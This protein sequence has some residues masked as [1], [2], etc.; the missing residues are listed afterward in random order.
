M[1]TVEPAVNEL[2]QATTG[3]Q[4]L[5][6]CGLCIKSISSKSAVKCA[7]CQV[8]CHVS[9]IVTKFVASG[10][11]ECKHSKEW[12]G[13]FLNAGPFHYSCSTCLVKNPNKSPGDISALTTVPSA[14]PQ[15]C[16]DV[17]LLHQEVAGMKASFT[18]MSG[19]MNQM[20]KRMSELQ[21]SLSLC[22][23]P[24][25]S[26]QTKQDEDKP[27]SAPVS[28]REQ[29]PSHVSL[30]SDTKSFKEAVQQAVA[31]SIKQQSNKTR[32]KASVVVHGL[33]ENKQDSRDVA[34][35][36]R[37][38]SINCVPVTGF[39]M[40]QPPKAVSTGRPRPLKVIFGSQDDKFA[41]LRA[42]RHLRD[43]REFCAVHISTYLSADEMNKVKAKRAECER[44]NRE[45]GCHS[46]PRKYVV[47]DGDIKERG[48]DGKLK[49]YRPS[50]ESTSVVH[51][52][53]PRSSASTVT[54][55]TASLPTESARPKPTSSQSK[56]GSVGSQAAPLI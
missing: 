26:G 17:A 24:V 52:T 33:P 36:L 45:C 28:V 39:R 5:S 7:T 46:S 11:K 35:M 44:L 56:N 14:E 22:A 21:S 34:A 48:P 54:N 29:P 50:A 53:A 47:I 20:M 55:I 3:S 49:A 4:E 25:S 37:A 13:E 51:N 31:T 43:S 16:S 32:D 38:M 8:S 42:A 27:G 23:M 6:V 19:D 40:G 12:L 18:A 15:H 41:V 30:F 1:A 2:S 9:C 10:G